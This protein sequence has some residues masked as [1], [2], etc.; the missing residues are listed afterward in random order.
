MDRYLILVPLSAVVAL[1]AAWLIASRILKSPAGN[2]EGNQITEVLKTGAG[3]FISRQ[4]QTVVYVA[5]VITAVFIVIALIY[6]GADAINWWWTTAGFVAGILF[7]GISGYAGMKIALG[8][9]RRVANASELTRV[10]KIA[11]DGGAVSGLSVAGFALLGLAAFFIISHAIIGLDDPVTPLLGLGFGAALMSFFAR[12]GGGIFSNAFGF[13]ANTGYSD[14][15]VSGSNPQ[16]RLVIAGKVG[17]RFQEYGGVRADLFDTYTMAGIGAVFLGYLLPDVMEVTALVSY[18]LY[19]LAV[20]LLISFLSIIIMRFGKDFDLAKTI[21]RAIYP[22]LFLSGVG[23]LILTYV[24]FIDFDFAGTGGTPP[25]TTWIDLFLSS[26]AGLLTVAAVILITEYYSPAGHGYM[27]R[28]GGSSESGEDNNG[29]AAGMESTLLPSLAIILAIFIA[30]TFAGIYG[31]GIAAVAMVSIAGVVVT[32]STYGLTWIAEAGDLS[33][34]IRAGAE[35]LEVTRNAT[36]AIATGFGICAAALVTLVLF[37]NYMLYLPDQ[38]M[39]FRLDDPIV[40]AGL[41]FGIMLPFLFVSVLIK[42]TGNAEADVKEDISREFKQSSDELDET[43]N[44]EYETFADIITRKSL[45]KLIVPGLMAVFIP[46]V[47]GL[48]MGPLALGGLLIGAIVSGLMVA[49][50]IS[51][52]DIKVGHLKNSDNGHQE[53][54][55]RDADAASGFRYGDA[56]GT[57]IYPLIKIISIV[58]IIFSGMIAVFGGILL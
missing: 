57:A 9:S 44:P 11:V 40:I 31:I 17:D 10:F 54:A 30:Y 23:F 55:G 51:K 33:D 35:E 13:A 53:I 43:D 49:L 39:I 28:S 16:N 46:L 12:V 48:F 26:A 2:G 27:R 32:L 19:L 47:A 52:S 34:E 36:K 1:I 50:M 14:S 42:V 58:A 5:A 38:G 20:A 56:T 8:I 25:G 45:R 22:G 7:S 29:L 18:P 15:E 24:M 3:A 4:Y 6:D 21:N 41:I 37:L